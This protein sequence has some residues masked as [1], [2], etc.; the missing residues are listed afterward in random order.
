MTELCLLCPRNCL[1]N[2]NTDK[3]FCG[4]GT[5]PVVAKAFPH[6]GEEPSIS[7]TKGSGTVFFSGCNLQCS[8][9]QNNL[10][11]GSGKGWEIECDQLAQIFLDLQD[12]GVHNINLVSPTHQSDAIHQALQLVKN[13]LHIPVVWNSGGYDTPEV[14]E[15]I[16]P[17][18]QI[19]LP[20]LKFHSSQLSMKMAGIS[21]YFEKASRAIETMVLHAKPMHIDQDGM[22]KSG[23]MIRHLILPGYSQD[24]IRLME[25]VAGMFGHTVQM[26]LMA[27][28]TPMPNAEHAP[29]RVL[30][31]KELNR[32]MEAAAKL[33]LCNG[34]FQDLA[35]AG[36]E[37]LPVFDGE[38]VV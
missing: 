12:K 22:M 8:F 14:I 18:I 21:N 27:Q 20:D 9:C 3:G 31:Q 24:S 6:F 26:S 30:T 19:W 15:K 35:A 33:G 16:A 37:L 28:Y 25:W 38:G 23:V 34:Y 17:Y 7:G 32:V 4:I 1:V 5:K 29:Q 11:S 36:F 2:R 10:I 13:S